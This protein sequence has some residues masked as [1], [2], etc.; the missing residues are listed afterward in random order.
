M[1]NTVNVTNQF[2]TLPLTKL[3]VRWINYGKHSANVLYELVVASVF[4]IM[5]ISP[6]LLVTNPTVPG[7]SSSTLF[8][9]VH[10]VSNLR[11]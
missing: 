3:I 10:Y 8:L 7:K 2:S 6:E 9:L 5:I 1:R 4:W 11:K